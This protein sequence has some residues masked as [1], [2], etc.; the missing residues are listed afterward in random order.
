[1]SPRRWSRRPFLRWSAAGAAEPYLALQAGEELVPFSDYTPEF[2][3][4]VQANHPRVKCFDLRRL[5]S[6]ATPS[7]EFFA[8]R[9]TEPVRADAKPWPCASPGLWSDRRSFRPK[10]CLCLAPAGLQAQHH[11]H[12]NRSGS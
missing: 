4:E 12:Q 9:Q 5:T 11:Q 7:E 2:R 1:L 3:A 10:T 8:F 6:W